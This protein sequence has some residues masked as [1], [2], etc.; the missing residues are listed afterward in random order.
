MLDPKLFTYLELSICKYFANDT[1]KIYTPRED[2]EILNRLIETEK[3][4]AE[5]KF[6][7]PSPS[8]PTEIES[9]AEILIHVMCASKDQ[10]NLIVLPD[11]VGFF[12]SKFTTTIPVKKYS[13]DGTDFGCLQLITQPIDIVDWGKLSGINYKSIE[14]MYVYRKE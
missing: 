10:Q 12:A 11:M 6:N 5:I 9:T 13:D 14:A 1:Y 7:G 8:Q 4:W 3:Q 2:Q